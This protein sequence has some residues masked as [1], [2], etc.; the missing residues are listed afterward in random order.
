M[1]VVDPDGISESQAPVIFANRCIE[2][3]MTDDEKYAR[4]IEFF[5][6]ETRESAE[7]YYKKRPPLDTSFKDLFFSKTEVQNTL[8]AYNLDVTKFWYL[9]LFIYDVVKDVCSRAPKHERSQIDMVNDTR[10][11]K[12]MRQKMSSYFLF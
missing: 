11:D 9:L 1:P 7:Q 8:K 2:S 3:T 10:E 5:P 6:N 4:F 12:A